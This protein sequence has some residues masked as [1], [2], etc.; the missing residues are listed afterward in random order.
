MVVSYDI[1]I[2]VNNK[3]GTETSLF[4]FFLGP[5]AKKFLE[6]IVGKVISTRKMQPVLASITRSVQTTVQQIRSAPNTPPD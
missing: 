6:E 2:F 1:T 5:S 3:S 4:E